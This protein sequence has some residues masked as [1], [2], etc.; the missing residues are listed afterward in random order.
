MKDRPST[1]PALQSYSYW[2]NESF[3]VIRAHRKPIALAELDWTYNTSCGCYETNWVDKSYDLDHNVSDPVNK[4]IAERKIRY[5]RSEDGEWYYKIPDRLQPGT[6]QLEYLVRDV[7]GAWS[8][9]F[10]MNFTLENN[11]PPQLRAELRAED[12]AF[13]L[14]GGVPASE[15]IRAHSLWTRFP[16][17]VDLQFLMN[18]SGNILSRT[19]PYHTGT[20]TGSEIFWADETFTIPQTTLDGN[21]TF[22]V[23]AV[24]ANGTSVHKNFSVRVLTPINLQPGVEKD[25]APVGTLV[26]GDPVTLTARTTE[27]PNQVTV[28][29]FKGT[30]HQR[31]VTL[32][33]VTQ[34][35]AGVGVKRWSAAFTPQTPILDGTYTFEWTAQTPNGKTETKSLQLTLVNNRPPVADFD[36][37]PKPP[38]EG[39]T[40]T[41]TNKSSDPDGDVLTYQ[42]TISGPNGYSRSGTSRDFTVP[43]SDTENRTGAYAVTLTVR[44]P[45]GASSTITKTITVLPLG[46]TGYVTHTE[47]WQ[48]KIDRFNSGLMP[49]DENYRQPNEFWAGEAFVL[50]A[51]TTNTGT[52]TVATKVEVTAD[53]SAIPY[54]WN[55]KVIRETLSPDNAAK[56]KWNG[57][58]TDRSVTYTGDNNRLENLQ[59]GFLDI[60]FKVTY[61]NGVVKTDTVRVYVK[62]KWTEFYQI[63]R[64]Q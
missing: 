45:K 14:T 8:D 5:Y 12:S 24:G 54:W 41:L 3:T 62:N 10:V 55:G 27:Y 57:E 47:T 44:D 53:G 50:K 36:W 56:T 52:A 9:P 32:S 33:G 51:D 63:H 20:K 6:Y 60:E 28:T 37:S 43:G 19:V 49:T 40:I 4:G 15:K 30:S 58:I 46:I 16:Y 38:F 22:R 13:T 59:N 18:P 2:S 1:D 48:E 21:Y 26:V 35:T 34:S 25:G 31:T 61:S 29:A 11:P 42:W 39:D 64:V 7:E 23:R 17:S